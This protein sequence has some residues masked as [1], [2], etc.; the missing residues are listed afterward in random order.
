MLLSAVTAMLA[1]AAC[2]GGSDPAGD[3]ESADL[4][5]FASIEGV[6]ADRQPPAVPVDGAVAGGTVTVLYDYALVPAEMDPTN[7]YI[8]VPISVLGGLV[9][10][11]LTQWVVDPAEEAMVLIPDLATDLGTPNEDFTEWTYTI[12]DGVRFEDGTPVT[13]DEVA[14]GI[15]RS[16][17]RKSFPD[18]PSYSNDYFLDGDTY[19]GPYRSGTDYDG[20]VV[21]GDTLTVKMATPVPRHAVLGGVPGDG[22]DPDV[23]GRR[24]QGI[25]TASGGDRAVQV[26]RVF[27]RVVDPGPQRPVGRR[28]RPGPTP[29]PRSLRLRLRPAVRRHRLD[30]PGGRRRSR[31]DAVHREPLGV[32]AGG[33]GRDGPGRHRQRRAARMAGSPTF[34]SLTTSGSGRRSATPT[35]MRP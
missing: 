28:H 24:P 12:R 23:R 16:F 5:E 17:D 35:R 30:H 18:G 25:R 22:P 10:R 8:T 29:V 3:E 34:G 20:V 33:G 32:G 15:K 2:D 9:T 11:S 13:A 14:Y 21:D 26:R 27:R 4:G 6:D 7:A 19:Q 31:H 1:L